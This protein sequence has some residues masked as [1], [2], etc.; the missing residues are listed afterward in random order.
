MSS[1]DADA[2]SLREKFLKLRDAYGGGDTS[3]GLFRRKNIGASK[4]FPMVFADVVGQIDAHL[5]GEAVLSGDHVE[6]LEKRY[7]AIVLGI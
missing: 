5:S 3:K 7:E 2:I 6:S 4:G 1:V